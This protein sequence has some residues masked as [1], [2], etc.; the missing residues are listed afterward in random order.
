M[1]CT[2]NNF[3]VATWQSVVVNADA[4]KFIEIRE[5][6]GSQELVADI[7][8]LSNQSLISKYE[9]F[10][11]DIDDRV[12][13]LFLLFTGE[14]PHYR[15]MN[16]HSEDEVFDNENVPLIVGQPKGSEIKRVRSLTKLNQTDFA[17]L[18]GRCT[19]G[20]ISKYEKGE[21]HITSRSWAVI[22]LATNQHPNYYLIPRD[23]ELVGR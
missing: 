7:L 3:D 8:G 2:K 21:R 22:L 11:S 16:R 13:T 1:S 12:Y 20:D 6:F 10:E 19:K 4:N 9:N 14:H 23:S 15:L 18:W 5:D 17:K